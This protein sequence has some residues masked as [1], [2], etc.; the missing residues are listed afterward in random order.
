MGCGMIHPN[1]LRFANIDPD[2]Y[3]GFAWG[4]GVD[5]LIMIKNNIP[6]IRHLRA[7]SIKF[8]REY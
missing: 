8:L 6:E 3:S 2:E 5:R 7:G 4:F 1:V